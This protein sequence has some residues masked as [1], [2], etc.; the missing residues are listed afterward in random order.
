MW[1]CQDYQGHPGDDNRH[2]RA[3]YK[4]PKWTALHLHDQLALIEARPD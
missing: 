3:K 1:H 2:L 4:N